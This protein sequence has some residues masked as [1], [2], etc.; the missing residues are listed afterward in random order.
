MIRIKQVEI[1]N[2]R[3]CINSKVEINNDLTTL[4]GINGVGKSNILNSIQLLKRINRNR[5]FHKKSIQESLLHTILK[6][7][8][9]IDNIK[10]DLKADIFYETDERNIDEIYSSELSLKI[11]TSR[12]WMKV[13]PDLFEVINRFKHMGK[14]VQT[15]MF[16]NKK[17]DS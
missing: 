16:S 9:D 13:D 2:Y 7:K 11:A 8:L 6:F 4:I 14:P 15:S 1:T 5:Y 3:S 12:K 17:F 10:Y